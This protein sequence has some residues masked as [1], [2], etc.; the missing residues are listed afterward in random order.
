MPLTLYELWAERSRPPGKHTGSP[1][2]HSWTVLPAYRS[3][4]AIGG[5]LRSARP[6]NQAS[7]VPN[8]ATAA[9]W[10]PTEAGNGPEM[11]AGNAIPAGTVLEVVYPATAAP[12]E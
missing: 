2:A 12:C 5:A 11:L 7:G 9:T 1:V 4:M 3:P 6:R 10:E 8:R